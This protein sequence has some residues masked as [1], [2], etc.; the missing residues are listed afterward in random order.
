MEFS[1]FRVDDIFDIK[2]SKYHNPKNYK[3]GNIP[4]VARTTF[5]NG[6]IDVISTDERLYEANCI[7]IGAESA[8]AF[9]QKNPFI[10]GN[11]IYRLYLKEKFTIKLNEKIALYFCVLLN[12]VGLKYD[13]TNAFISSR[14][15][16]EILELPIKNNIIDFK[17]MENYIKNIEFKMQELVNAYKMV[18]ARER[19]REREREI[20]AR[21]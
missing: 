17:F 15:K 13:Y 7:I 8:R 20:A 6:V 12:K 10:T 4:Y 16:N 2:C 3:K 21:P 11:K 9:Y 5:N 14:V 18:A 19:E 1:K